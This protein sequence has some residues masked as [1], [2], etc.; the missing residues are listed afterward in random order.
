MH[1]TP[2]PALSQV[3]NIPPE[4]NYFVILLNHPVDK[5]ETVLLKYWQLNASGGTG[6]PPAPQTIPLKLTATGSGPQRYRLELQ[7]KQLVVVPIS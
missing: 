2:A 1:A 7:D 5:P 3:V 6:A 4:T